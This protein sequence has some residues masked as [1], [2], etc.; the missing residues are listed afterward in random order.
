MS[1]YIGLPTKCRRLPSDT[2]N[3]EPLASWSKRN[4]ITPSGARYWLGRR[5]VKAWKVGGK[6]YV[7]RRVNIPR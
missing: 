4:S 2:S 1:K 3:L 5:R 6:W 7:D